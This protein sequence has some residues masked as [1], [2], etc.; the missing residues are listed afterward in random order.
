MYLCLLCT[1]KRYRI[2]AGPALFRL[3]PQK[4]LA[5]YIFLTYGKLLVLVLI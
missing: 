2:V 1:Y 5:I 4:G 3:H